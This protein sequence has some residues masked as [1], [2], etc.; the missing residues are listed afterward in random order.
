MARA[1]AVAALVLYVLF[2][3]GG[4]YSFR[5]TARVWALLYLLVHDL[6]VPARVPDAWRRRWR[7]AAGEELPALFHD[8]ETPPA[9]LPNREEIARR[10]RQAAHRF[11]C[12]CGTVRDVPRHQRCA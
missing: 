10:N 4:G 2:T 8:P 7:G 3:L 12:P 1:L 11:A 6:P 9:D 5:A